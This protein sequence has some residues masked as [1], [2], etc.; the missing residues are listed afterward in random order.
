[1]A[2]FIRFLLIRLHPLPPDSVSVVFG[3]PTL[4]GRP[5]DPRNVRCRA[6][7]GVS[8]DRMWLLSDFRVMGWVT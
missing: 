4:R 8:A 5:N 3:S 2:G 6:P 7:G 1:M